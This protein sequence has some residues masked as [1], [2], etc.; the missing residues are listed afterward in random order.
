MLRLLFFSA[1]L[2]LYF[3][4]I[5]YKA[6]IGILAA[7]VRRSKTGIISFRPLDGVNNL[8]FFHFT[9]INTEFFCFSFYFVKCHI[10]FPLSIE[11]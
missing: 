5:L 10:L 8:R 7:A 4:A 9:A 6:A 2:R 1:Y 3:K 11:L